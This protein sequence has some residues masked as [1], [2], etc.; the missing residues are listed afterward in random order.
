MTGHALWYSSRA[1]GLVSL[2]LLTATVVLGAL[3]VGRFA[4]RRWPRFAI[5][6]VHRNI[7]LLTVVFLAVHVLTA[8]I[9][10]YAGIGWL[11]VIIPFSSVYRPF[12]LGLGALAGDLALAVVATSLLRARIGVRAWRAVHWATYACWPLAVV[13]GLGIGGVDSR[14]GWILAVTGGCVLAAVAAVGWRLSAVHPDT[15]ARRGGRIQP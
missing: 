8:V 3:H 2:V 11:D 5:A 9:D 7:A 6:A 4:T 14:T 12:W 15:V 10:R 1:A 13:H